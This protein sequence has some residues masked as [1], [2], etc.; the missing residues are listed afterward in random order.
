MGAAGVSISRGLSS[1]KATARLR[2]Q[3]A[4]RAPG[5]LTAARPVRGHAGAHPARRA[6]AAAAA[7][8]ACI[9]PAS[10]RLNLYRTLLVYSL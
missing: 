2:A 10:H 4:G 9:I 8:K 1:A 6:A 3:R 7:V 5:P